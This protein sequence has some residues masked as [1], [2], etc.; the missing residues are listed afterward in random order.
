[1]ERVVIIEAVARV[2]MA[3]VTAVVMVLFME[4]VGVLQAQFSSQWL[5][6]LTINFLPFLIPFPIGR[7]SKAEC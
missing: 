5:I 4:V 6:K 1:M 3:A 2:V 7:N